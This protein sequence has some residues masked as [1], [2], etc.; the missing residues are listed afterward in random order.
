MTRKY[1]TRTEDQ[2]TGQAGRDTKSAFVL[3]IFLIFRSKHK[4]EIGSF[5]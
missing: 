2:S 3:F 5:I 1:Q 4:Q